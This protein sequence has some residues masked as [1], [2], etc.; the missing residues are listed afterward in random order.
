MSAS[1]GNVF[2][3][4]GTLSSHWWFKGS[5]HLLAL[6]SLI[7][8]FQECWLEE[9]V[10]E[11]LQGNLLLE[12]MEVTMTLSLIIHCLELSYKLVILSNELVI[13]VTA[14]SKTVYAMEYGWEPR[15][16]RT[17]IWWTFSSKFKYFSKYIFYT[18]HFW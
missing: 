9:K 8:G 13:M 1:Y 2:L 18:L 12:D 4:G 17:C 5:C 3:T 11:D 6:P 15:R 7:Q 16:K 10:L 14:K